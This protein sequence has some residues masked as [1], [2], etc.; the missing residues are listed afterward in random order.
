MSMSSCSLPCLH[1]HSMCVLHT[2]THILPQSCMPA[3]PLSTATHHGMAAEPCYACQTFVCVCPPPTHAV[4]KQQQPALAVQSCTPTQSSIVLIPPKSR[5]CMSVYLGYMQVTTH[6][7][8]LNAINSPHYM[9]TTQQHDECLRGQLV[10]C[11]AAH[12]CL[13][14]CAAHNIANQVVASAHSEP[15]RQTALCRHS[16]S[17]QPL[18]LPTP[19]AHTRHPPGHSFGRH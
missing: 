6:N 11:S 2:N 12:C 19:R 1:R 7:W 8:T 4:Q 3:G 18:F 13:A 9:Q 5:T 17:P 16:T 14:G 15:E 10:C